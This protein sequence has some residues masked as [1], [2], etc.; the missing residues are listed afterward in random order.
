MEKIKFILIGLLIVPVL[1]CSQIDYKKISKDVNNS[2]NK[3]KPLT[4]SEIIAG[5]KEALEVGSKN[6]SASTS[7]L[8][9][10]YKNPLIKIPFPPEA[11]EMESKLRSLG[12]NKQVDDFILTI[13][14][15]AE[16][17]A[18]QAAPVFINAIKGLTISDGMSIL[19]G[20]DTAATSYLRQKTAVDLHTRFKPVIK[21]ATQKVEVTKYWTPLANTY[22][23]I[24]FVK[25]VNPDLDEY[26]TQRGLSG[27][28]KVVSQ[29]EVKI[30]K[31]PS[32]R[33]TELLKK[34]FG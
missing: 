6:A 24:P 25:K 12:M 34:V 13:N 21:S 2:I 16:E 33:V 17:A 7:K 19:K 20:S 32:A 1:S 3:N 30:R 11:A 26:I 27:L 15:A 9:G 29:E 28:F 18:K 31:N 23:A 10:F 8:D 22:N 14:R 4:N 5:L